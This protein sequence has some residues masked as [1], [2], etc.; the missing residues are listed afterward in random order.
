MLLS[1]ILKRKVEYIPNGINLPVKSEANVSTYFN[2][3][4]NQYLLWIGR[5]SYQKGIE[6]LID[7]FKEVNTTQ[8]LVLVG[9]QYDA[10]EFYNEILKKSKG[11]ERIIFLGSR[12]GDE[13]NVLYSNAY[14]VIH[15][16]ETES[17]S[18]VTLESLAF[19]NCLLASDIPGI[20]NVAKEK[21]YYFKPKDVKSLK[22]IM[23]LL[24]NNP[25]MVE[26]KRSTARRHIIENFLWDDIIIQYE[27]IYHYT[28]KEGKNESSIS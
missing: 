3:E 26:E 15:P 2:L 14:I 22:E 8:K 16:S 28:L 4:N 10:D 7:A 19:G 25:N 21:A 27:K 9:Y 11:D 24:I 6:Y 23:Q 13:L 18:L 20:R 17:N 5:F 12:N 1:K